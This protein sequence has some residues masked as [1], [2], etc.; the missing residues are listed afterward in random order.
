MTRIARFEP[1]FTEPFDAFFRRVTQPVRWEVEGLPQEIRIDVR[2]NETGYVVKADLPGVSKDGVKVT[3]DGNAVAIGAEVRK[4]RDVE[5]G[6]KLIR[7]ERQYGT[8]YRSFMLET[9]VDEAAATATF[10][11]GTLELKLPKKATSAVKTLAI[12]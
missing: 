10:K 5:E 3:I 8:L 11:D 7:S 9:D 2:E 4:E 12:E 6:G 1:L